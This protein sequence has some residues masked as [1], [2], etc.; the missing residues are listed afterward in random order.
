MKVLL[1]CLDRCFVIISRNNH[2]LIE[3]HVR[4]L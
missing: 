4:L 2:L 1:L 3:P